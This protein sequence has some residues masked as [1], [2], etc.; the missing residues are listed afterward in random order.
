[1]PRD[2]VIYV[3]HRSTSVQRLSAEDSTVSAVIL[4]PDLRDDG[5]HGPSVQLVVG[6]NLQWYVILLLIALDGLEDMI[7]RS[8]D[9]S[10]LVHAYLE[11]VISISSDSFV[12]GQQ[13]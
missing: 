2:Y 5:I 10:E 9:Q 3:E 8:P 6:K 7:M 1:M 13:E 4:L 11:G 12:Y